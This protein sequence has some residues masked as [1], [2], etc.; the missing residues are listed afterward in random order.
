MNRTGAQFN[1]VS[2]RI[3]HGSAVTAKVFTLGNSFELSGCD[4]YEKDKRQQQAI[5]ENRLGVN[6]QRRRAASYRAKSEKNRIAENHKAHLASSSSHSDRFGY[7]DSHTA[8]PGPAPRSRSRTDHHHQQQQRSQRPQ[9]RSNVHSDNSRSHNKRQSSNRHGSR[10]DPRR[11][12]SNMRAPPRS[13]LRSP[14]SNSRNNKEGEEERPDLDEIGIMTSN[15]PNNQKQHYDTRQALDEHQA[16]QERLSRAKNMQHGGE[17]HGGTREDEGVWYT[18]RNAH[19]DQVPRI[20]QQKQ[21][22]KDAAY[23]QTKNTRKPDAYLNILLGK[24]EEQDTTAEPQHEGK[25]NDG[26]DG[27]D[28]ADEDYEFEKKAKEL[29]LQYT[30]KNSG[31]SSSYFPADTLSP[32]GA[33]TRGSPGSIQKALALEKELKRRRRLF[34]ME[35]GLDSH[36]NSPRSPRRY[37]FCLLLLC[38]L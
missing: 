14:K 23:T 10:V 2:G 37:V 9:Q 7:N 3:E 18:G 16:H 19:K 25:Y 38:T 5:K 26:A 6:Q 35:A 28:V 8:G 20:K 30:A 34:E 24:A 21:T 33:A 31:D 11:K 36:S 4:Y 29:Q 15:N 13:P 22:A 1:R 32:R 17:G 12:P 27:A